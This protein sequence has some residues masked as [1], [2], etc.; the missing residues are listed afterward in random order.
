[1]KVIYPKFVTI[2]FN[3][4]ILQ[5]DQLKSRMAKGFFKQ[6][7]YMNV[8]LLRQGQEQNNTKMSFQTTCVKLAKE[9][10]RS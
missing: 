8:F 2:I 10:T 5:T 3:G 4:D 6:R 1:M 7:I 9:M